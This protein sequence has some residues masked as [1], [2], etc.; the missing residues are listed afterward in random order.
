MSYILIADVN[1][2]ATR[3]K[4]ILEPDHSL[5]YVSTV[6]EA[7]SFV[8]QVK[9]D[10][11]IIGLHFDESRMY[12]LM[13]QMKAV[14]SLRGTPVMGFSDQVTQCSISSRN[15][16]EGSTHALGVC[17]YVDT[18]LMT[19]REILDRING[20][21]TGKLGIGRK[22]ALEEK[23]PTQKRERQERQR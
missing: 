14:P 3:L 2:G 12:E 17:D 15:S 10:L 5:A 4:N 21:L 18:Q 7:L 23:S 20:C 9:F 22:I 8:Q 1:R 16:I 19:D 11:V 13:S 6:Q